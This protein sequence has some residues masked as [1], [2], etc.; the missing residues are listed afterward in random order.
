MIHRALRR[1]ERE[2]QHLDHD[3]PSQAI[4]YA[5][6]SWRECHGSAHGFLKEIAVHGARLSS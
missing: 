5:A 6:P 2:E 4:A 3:A 1:H